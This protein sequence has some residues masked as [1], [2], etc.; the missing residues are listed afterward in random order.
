MKKRERPYIF[1]K[2]LRDEMKKG[3]SKELRKEIDNIWE[4]YVGEPNRR[5]RE[6]QLKKS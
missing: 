5:I 4:K 2:K 1:T 3:L 6:Q